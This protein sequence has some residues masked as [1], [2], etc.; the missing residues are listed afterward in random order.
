[1]SSYAEN[2]QDAREYA[3]LQRQFAEEAE[4]EKIVITMDEIVEHRYMQRRT[5][6]LNQINEI[7]TKNILH[8]QPPHIR[9]YQPAEEI[10][11]DILHDLTSLKQRNN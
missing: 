3:E 8:G 6:L 4:E 7:V 5:E 11:D 9:H 10:L 1:M 2:E